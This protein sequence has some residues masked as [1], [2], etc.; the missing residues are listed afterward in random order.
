M[1]YPLFIL[2][3]ILLIINI[4]YSLKP[5]NPNQPK[6]IITPPYK[7]DTIV[8]LNNIYLNFSKWTLRPESYYELS[9]LIDTLIKYPSLEI[10][11]QA[12][13]DNIGSV[14][15]NK[16][17]SEKRAASV[18]QY[19]ISNGIPSY[20]LSSTGFGES[21]PIVSNDTYQGR[22]INRRIEFKVLK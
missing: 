6:L 9:K 3:L 5:A 14:N 7:K 16:I 12:H 20:Q 1:E 21:L 10:R 8:K 11:I 19:L 13:T 22:Q 4:S 15:S 17:V 2:G 18:I